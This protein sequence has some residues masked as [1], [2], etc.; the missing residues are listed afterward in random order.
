M[1]LYKLPY[2]E[3]NRFNSDEWITEISHFIKKES[4]ENTIIP[5]VCH[6]AKIYVYLI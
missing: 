5:T 4:Y 6:S 2:L 1:S 3:I